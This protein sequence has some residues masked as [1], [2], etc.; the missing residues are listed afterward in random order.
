MVLAR[1]WVSSGDGRAT[2]RG[3]RGV[4]LTC[5]TLDEAEQ[6]ADLLSAAMPDPV[7]SRLGLFELLLNA[8]EH[9]NLEIGRALKG[10]LL[11]EGR[12]EA[13]LAAR[14]AREPYRQRAVHVMI[15]QAEPSVVMEIRDEGPGFDWRKAVTAEVEYSDAPNG[16]GVALVR[17][18]CFPELEY[19]DPGNVAIVRLAW[20][21]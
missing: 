2:L 19:R 10:E 7:H 16:R 5:R 3:L 14:L 8:I 17:N 18:S 1:R 11:R 15:T 12:F 21:S 6:L 4:E 13:E 20:P 9:G